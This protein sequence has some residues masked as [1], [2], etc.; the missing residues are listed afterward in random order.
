MKYTSVCLG[1]CAL[2]A[3]LMIAGWTWQDVLGDQ[4]V[5]TEEQ[6]QKLNEASANFHQV[7]HAH[8]DQ[9]AHHHGHAHAHSHARVTDDDL[10][11]AKNAWREQM[12]ERDA[13]IAWRDF[14]RA[15]LL[16]GGMA[17]IMLGGCGYLLMKNQ[18]S[19][20]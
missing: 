6:A 18:T 7:A 10:A 11:A 19:D 17:A 14:W 12:E 9:Q 8:G 4:V 20:V 13:A 2:G 5:W 15:A 1:L 16:R 3:V